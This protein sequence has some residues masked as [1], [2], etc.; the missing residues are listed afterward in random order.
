MN[1]SKVVQVSSVPLHGYTDTRI[2]GYPALQIKHL[3]SSVTAVPGGGK[4]RGQISVALALVIDFKRQTN[5]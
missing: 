3:V 2:H 4:D 5:K 1:I